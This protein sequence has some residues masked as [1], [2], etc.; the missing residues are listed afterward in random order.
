MSAPA[1]LTTADAELLRELHAE[2]ADA[3]WSF[4]TRLLDGDRV[5]SQDVVQETF[6]RAWRHPEVLER[7]DGSARSW[8]FT[9]A[10]HLVVDEWRARRRRPEVLAEAPPEPVASRATAA[11]QERLL[12]RQV[13][14]AALA[15]LTHEHR[16]VVVECYVKGSSVSQAAASLGIPPGTVKSRCHYALRELRTVLAAQGGV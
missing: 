8:L 10:R 12:D 11:P 13:L 7:T 6:L 16:D 1:T 5:R 9:V 14:L 2:H 3:L 4:V 15:T